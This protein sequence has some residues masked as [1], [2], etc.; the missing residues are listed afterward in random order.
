MNEANSESA[1][2]AAAVSQLDQIKEHTVVVADTGDFGTMKAY[3]PR[4]ATTNPS[5][6]FS[7][8]QMD[9]YEYLLEKAIADNERSGLQGE[10]LIDR[11]IDHLLVDFGGEILKIVPGRVSTEVDARLSFDIEGSV[12]KAREIIALY[13][14]RGI[15][16]D[17]ILI[18]VAATW[19]GARAT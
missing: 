11:I 16:R 10:A 4:D 6:I 1:A 3:A 2:T 5:L 14:T 9:D 7:A 19:E 8:V 13:E 18:K 12:A 15:T 17:R